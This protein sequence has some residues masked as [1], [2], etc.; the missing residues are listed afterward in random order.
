M[1][2]FMAELGQQAGMAARCPELVILTA[3][4]MGEAIGARWSEIDLEAAEVVVHQ[5]RGF[6]DDSRGPLPRGR[7]EPS[8]HGSHPKGEA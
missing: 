8:A 6:G 3:T 5:R 7:S 1:P 4:R 2:A